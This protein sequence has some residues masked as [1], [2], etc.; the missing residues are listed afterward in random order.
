MKR[1]LST[2]AIALALALTAAATPASAAGRAGINDV[3]A[4]HFVVDGTNLKAFERAVNEGRLPT[5]KKTFYDGG[6][7]FTHGLSLF[8]TT[9]TTVYQ[10]Y[11]TGLLPGHAGIPHLERM[12]RQTEDVIG[13]LTVSGFDRI[14]SDLINLRALTNP[15]VA[16]LQ[17][18]T[19]IFELL[20]GHPTEV[21]YSSFSRGATGRHPK[22]AP[23]RALWSTYVSDD[24]ENVD[25][26]AM[27]RVMKI[28]RRPLKKI[29]RYTMVG[30]YSSDIMGHRHGPHSEEVQ[31]VLRQFD[32]FLRDFLRLIERRG[33]AERTY[34][35]VSADHGMHESG[36]LFDLNGALARAGFTMKTPES[37]RGRYGIYAAS[38]GVASSHIYVRHDRGFE[39]ITD[40][41]IP[42]H[43]KGRDGSEIDLIKVLQGLDA[44][45]LVAVRA[46]ERKARIFDSEGASAELSC[47]TIAGEDYCSYRPR[48][49]DPLGYSTSPAT[50]RLADGRP[51]SAEAW[52][53]ASSG[54]R[55]PDA[56]IGLSQIFRDG[57]AGDI[58]ITTKGRY[59]FRKVKE[60]NHGGL[61]EED[62]RTPFMISGPTVPKGRFHTARPVDLYP[63]TLEWFGLD[64]PEKNYDGTDPFRPHEK[65]DARIERLAAAEQLME[66][67]GRAGVSG[68]LKP[69]ARQE[70][71]K[72]MQ[73]VERLTALLSDMKRGD[74]KS[75]YAADH[76]AIVERA[77]AWARGAHER[78]ERLAR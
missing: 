36:E 65:E 57:R 27:K 13:Y 74:R 32:V 2:A 75:P 51:H 6:A 50:K 19:T 16:E 58:F 25:F 46:G 53:H 22:R 24:V 21:I 66:E 37:R 47:F 48:G 5:V 33:I 70:A 38:R 59:G 7:V 62:M 56:V 49:G 54:E 34:I 68:D 9:S 18:Q 30:L 63:L 42:R 11:V 64:V 3:Y 8:P 77:L 26:L 10:S 76:I 1:S 12:D 78:M 67:R 72:R 4:I 23:V 28:F 69:L 43:M 40:P 35:V 17:P 45:E 29:P 14:N 61:M 15:E 55:Y 60:G 52:K 20:A 39:P 71:A 44:T 31:Q 73:L 41:E